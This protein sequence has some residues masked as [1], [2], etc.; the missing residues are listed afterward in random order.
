MKAYRVRESEGSR[1]A[2]F[3]LSTALNKWLTEHGGEIVKSCASCMHMR[4][5]GPAFCGKF[6]MTPPIDVIAKGCEKYEDES[7]IPF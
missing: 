1:D 4:R 7:D 5:E 2:A 3:A 6:N